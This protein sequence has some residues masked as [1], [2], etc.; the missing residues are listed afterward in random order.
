MIVHGGAYPH[1]GVPSFFKGEVEPS[2]LTTY[3]VN[4]DGMI[5]TIPR[6][7]EI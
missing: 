5:I 6:K 7:A 4:H 3:P 2:F 1:A